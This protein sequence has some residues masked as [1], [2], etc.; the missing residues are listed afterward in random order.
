MEVDKE[1][2]D[3]YR[4]GVETG[5]MKSATPNVVRQL[6]DEVERLRGELDRAQQAA[7]VLREH[8][9]KGLE[10]SADGGMRHSPEYLWPWLEEEG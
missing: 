5:A 3:A 2:L 8:T 4:R 6:L 9:A 10:V 1:T 7:R